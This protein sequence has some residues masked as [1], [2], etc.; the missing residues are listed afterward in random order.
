[1]A[2]F[3]FFFIALI[4]TGIITY[5]SLIN[6][7]D[8]PVKNLGMSDKAMHAGAYFGMAFLWLIFSHFQAPNINL[9]KRI[10]IICT[11]SIIFG[12]FIEVLQAVLT[13]YREPDLYD[14]LANSTGA[15]FAGLLVWLFKEQLNQVKV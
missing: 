7:A 6:L 10:L 2:K 13:T 9:I 3:I 11:L 4:Y 8:T 12:I 5:L 15:I 14:I 1:M